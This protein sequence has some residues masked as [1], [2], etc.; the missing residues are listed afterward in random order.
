MD[1]LKS[2]LKSLLPSYGTIPQNLVTAAQNLQSQSM[3]KIPHL[4]P[5]EESGRLY[6]CAHLACERLTTSLNLPDLTPQPPMPPK[7]YKTLLAQFRTALES[8]TTPS[9]RRRSS[10]AESGTPTSTSSHVVDV[11]SGEIRALCTKLGATTGIVHIISLVTKLLPLHPRAESRAGVIAAA[12]VLVHQR[13]STPTNNTSTDIITA[14]P[15][16]LS[17]AQRKGLLDALGGVLQ[18][19][20]LDKWVEIVREDC[21]GHDWLDGIQPQQ[22]PTK[23][24]T[25]GSGA[26]TPS[27]KRKAADQVHDDIGTPTPTST[28]ANS[29]MAL[30]AT[31]RN[32]TQ[33][34]AISG[35]GSMI[36][37]QVDY[38]SERRVKEYEVWKKGVMEK[39]DA[40][41]KE[42]EREEEGDVVMADV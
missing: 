21:E 9:T 4:K 36:V 37:P 41:E 32:K 20:E 42:R 12:Y 23:K 17:R 35:I 1:P 8:A 31:T 2:A 27:R 22:S 5:A 29:A 3:K 40:V 19:K 13:L 15:A 7:T 39:V 28:P 18:T 10:R 6:I 25:P 34:R 30:A 33:T 11:A 26:D 38:L 24:P 14:P 16:S